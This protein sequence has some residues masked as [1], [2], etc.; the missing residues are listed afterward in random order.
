[1]QIKQVNLEDL[2]PV[3]KFLLSYPLRPGQYHELSRIFAPLPL[4]IINR[5][6]EIVFGVDL[7]RFLASQKILET[8]ALQVEI[9]DQEALILN[10]NLKNKFTGL[11][12]YEKLVFI[13][14]ILPLVPVPEIYRKSGLDI[15][16]NRELEENLDL[17]LSTSF[18]DALITGYIGL[19]TGLRLCQFPVEDCDILLDLFKRVSFSSSHQLKIVEMT[20]EILFRD[21]C[22]LAEIFDQLG[23][24]QVLEAERPQK[25]II[26]ALYKYRYPVYLEA[27]E[28]WQQEINRLDLPDNIKVIHPPF[29]EKKTLELSIRVQDRTE[30]IKLIEKIKQ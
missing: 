13:K 27:E 1:M 16:L 3:D 15:P 20:E 11:N 9:A 18:R 19:K 8:A 2:K 5:E 17:L 30:L 23:F 29:F 26:A 6:A 14:K 21:K 4:L 10:Y 7:F 24:E 12:L 22:P 28:K 25:Q